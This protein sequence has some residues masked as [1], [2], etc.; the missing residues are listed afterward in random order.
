MLE[1]HTN[2]EFD[3]SDCSPLKLTRRAFLKSTLL[4]PASAALA[5]DVKRFTLGAKK[6][7][8]ILYLMTDQHRGDCLGCAGNPVIKT[9]HL[10]SIAKEGV[11]FSSPYS[12]TPSSTPARSPNLTG[13]SPWRQGKIG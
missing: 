13:L 10:D 4:V 7:P 8:N 12:S 5:A 6:R 3:M 1:M 9:P 2:Q 11:V